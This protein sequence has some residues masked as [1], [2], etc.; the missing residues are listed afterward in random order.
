MKLQQNQLLLEPHIHTYM[1]SLFS[2]V[3][4]ANKKYINLYL[5]ISW[6]LRAQS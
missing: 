4:E 1:T 5:F 2:S 3:T 6:H